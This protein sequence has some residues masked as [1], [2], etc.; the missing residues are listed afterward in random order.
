MA[1]SHLICGLIIPNLVAS[2]EV[3]SC[4][5]KLKFNSLGLVP[6]GLNLSLGALV[7]MFRGTDGQLTAVVCLEIPSA[8]PGSGP[9]AGPKPVKY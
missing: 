3:V 7:A 8:S 6:L 4:N 5:F 1:G 2:L 9:G